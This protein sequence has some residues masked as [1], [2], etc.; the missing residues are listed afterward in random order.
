MESKKVIILGAGFGGLWALRRLAG[1][2]LDVLIIDRHN[3][4]TF[5]PLLYQVGAAEL[6]PGEIAE[7]V[8]NIAR[9]N[10][11]VRFFMAEVEQVDINARTVR[12]GGVTFPYDYLVLAIGS[13]SVFYGIPGA[14]EFSYP[15]KGMDQALTI[16]NHILE[17]FERAGRETEPQRVEQLLT[18]AIAGGGP[19]GV[20]YAGALSELIRGPLAKDYPALKGKARIELFEAGKE[21][22][23]GYS[24]SL[25]GYA[26][27]RLEKMGVRVH[28]NTAVVEVTRDSVRVKDGPT[29]PTQTVIW[30]AGVAASTQ[31][32]DWRLPVD[33]H[34]QVKVLPTL[35]APEHP[36]VYVA[37]DLAYV[38]DKGRPL[39]ML[40]QPAIQEGAHAARNILRQ[41]NGQEPV[42]F[43]YKNLGTLAVIGRNA[44]VADI[45]GLQ[46]SGFIA[47]VI[48]VGVHITNLIG[49]RNRAVVLI[50]WAAD[51]F[52]FEKDIRLIL[53]TC[54]EEMQMVE[55]QHP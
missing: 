4:H 7:P 18:F 14:V 33:R 13:S 3:Y 49:F 41:A 21:L 31:G 30:T 26:A 53:P 35:Q 50:N 38:E 48:W 15:L 45:F 55:T 40:A 37:G 36:E 39:P 9:G 42:P 11:N 10:A 54:L 34:G 28:L 22:L 12:A 24:A 43:H 29:L 1:T 8:R 19:T 51:Y 44:A 46:L 23:S 52:F 5:F 27:R 47:W 20:E 16:R 32:R 6:T 2:P 17:C 25:T